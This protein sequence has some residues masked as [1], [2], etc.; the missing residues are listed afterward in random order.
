MSFS[1]SERS[2]GAG[3]SGVRYRYD[4]DGN[5]GEMEDDEGEDEDEF[6]MRDDR[7]ERGRGGSCG[8]S[9]SATSLVDRRGSS[10]GVGGRKA[11][12]GW[13]MSV[14]GLWT[15]VGLSQRALSSLAD[16]FFPVVLFPRSTCL[17]ISN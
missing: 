12:G 15:T 11:R 3:A 13:G 6:N 4:D 10:R 2:L 1:S 5:D 17:N 16:D 14:T 8:W 9:G 7:C